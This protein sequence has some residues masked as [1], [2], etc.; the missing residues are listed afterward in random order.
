MK[1]DQKSNKENKKPS[2]KEAKDKK[3]DGKFKEKNKSP[4]PFFR[5]L[6]KPFYSIHKVAFLF[7]ASDKHTQHSN[8]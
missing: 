6:R 4:I 8:I 5:W 1:V 2:N 7:F 3:E